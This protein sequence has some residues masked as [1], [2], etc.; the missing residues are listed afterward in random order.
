MTEQ[1]L[2]VM[3]EQPSKDAPTATFINALIG[4]DHHG[5]PILMSLALWLK[6]RT[7]LASFWMAT[8]AG[9]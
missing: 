2:N 8:T 3:I 9:N 1:L 7:T 5:Q 4:Y 6:A